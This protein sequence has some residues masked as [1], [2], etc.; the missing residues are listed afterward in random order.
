M[1]YSFVVP[2]SIGE[3]FWKPKHGKKLQ[4]LNIH[5][6]LFLLLVS[7]ILEINLCLLCW[8]K[9]EKKSL[10]WYLSLRKIKTQK[11]KFQIFSMTHRLQNILI[12]NLVVLTLTFCVYASLTGI[13]VDNGQQTILQHQ[14]TKDETF[15]VEHE[16]LDLLGL[17]DRPRRKRHIHP[18]LRWVDFMLR[19]N[20][21]QG[22]LEKSEGLFRW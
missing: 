17:A 7:N 4:N 16:I 21:L 5:S 8:K 10:N 2:G 19:T 9:R 3:T 18:S 15:E 11:E 13:Y 22:W 1:L 6:V 14:L 20:L 12:I